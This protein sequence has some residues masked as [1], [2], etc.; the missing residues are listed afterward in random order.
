MRNRVQITCSLLLLL[1]A[2]VLPTLATALPITV[3][4]ELTQEDFRNNGYLKGFLGFGPNARLDYTHP[5]SGSSFP[6]DVFDTAGL[7]NATLTITTRDDMDRNFEY[8]FVYTEG[9]WWN[10]DG[11]PVGGSQIF[12]VDIAQITDNGTLGVTIVAFL[13]D[14]YVTS[15]VL[16]LTYDNGQ[17]QAPVPEPGTMVL[18]GS[19]LLGAAALLRKK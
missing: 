16:R 10:G 5:S 12:N 18:L 6:G 1:G 13:G 14:F 17:A 3:V 8:G 7:L 15:S 2:L 9:E 11:L 19:G 4:D